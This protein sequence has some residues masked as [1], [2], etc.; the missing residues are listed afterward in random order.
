[1]NPHSTTRAVDVVAIGA[2]PFNLGLAA[3]ASTVDDLDLVVL[4]RAAEVS[5]H[6]GMLLD[7]A[8]LQVSFLADLVTLVAPTHP[9]SFLAYLADRDRMYPFYIRERFHPTRLEYQDYLRWAAARLPSVR[10]GHE[11]VSV[12]ETDDG[13]TVTAVH[14][15]EHVSWHAADLVLGVGTEPDIA[16]TLAGLPADRLLHTAD[17]LPRREQAVSARRVTVVGSGQ[18]GAEVFLDLLRAQTD[19]GPEITWLTRTESFAPLD[20]TKLVL[21]MTTP[22]YVRYFHSL[23]ENARYNLVAAQWRHYKGISTETLEAIH[24]QLYQRELRGGPRVELRAAVAV[25]DA[26][27]EEVPDSASERCHPMEPEP[28]TSTV[29]P[30]WSSGFEPGPPSEPR[31]PT[32]EPVI[33]S[34]H[35]SP[36]GPGADLATTVSLDPP[37]LLTTEPP[38]S[39]APGRRCHDQEPVYG[40]NHFGLARTFG[41]PDRDDPPG[42]ETG[43]PTTEVDPL[44]NTC[45]GVSL[46]STFSLEPDPDQDEPGMAEQD[47]ERSPVREQVSLRCLH[48]DTGESSWHA[49]DLVI[50]ATGYRRDFP[51]F[52]ASI[53]ARVRTDDRGNPR[54]RLDHSLEL[55]PTRAG[56]IFVSNADTHTHGVAAPDLGIGAWRNASIINTI[57]GREVYR[58]PRHTAY[59][60]FDP[61]PDFGRLPEERH[62]G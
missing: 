27:V 4:E 30:G 7:D 15:G 56:R 6:P 31:P 18:S 34:V 20:Y 21:E 5:W 22:E 47:H 52:L 37:P 33:A 26:F 32:D 41:L 50:A 61:R 38:L 8:S 19:E 40:P 44:T 43:A 10:F 53:R 48:R 60:T 57:V 36:A 16:D 29:N 42:Y 11:V 3:L 12:S 17:Y 25:T 24:D 51:A 1:M 35:V 2:G 49:T 13:F 59:T 14:R 55:D 58:L 45:P 9:L 46:G 28:L 39:V 54:V 62:H 23:P